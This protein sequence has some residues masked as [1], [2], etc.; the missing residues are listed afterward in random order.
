MRLAQRAI[1]VPA[2]IGLRAA[3][4]PVGRSAFT[5]S[6]ATPAGVPRAL[7]S[8]SVHVCI[9]IEKRNERHG[10]WVVTGIM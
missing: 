3:T 4:A 7:A 6:T 8:V 10:K 9:G 1:S 5:K 2:A